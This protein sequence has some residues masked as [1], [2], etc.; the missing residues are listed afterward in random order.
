MASSPVLEGDRLYI[1]CDNDD[2]SF[3]LALD[4]KTGKEIWR[5]DR[6]E[7]STWAT[8]FI[9][10]NQRRTELITSGA[11]KMRSYDLD[12]K[13][14]WELGGPLSTLAIPSPFAATGLLFL[15]SGYV[16]DEARPVFA[17]KPGARGDITL[18]P[19]ETSNE[20]IAWSLPQGGPL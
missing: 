5:V 6:E 3:L 4:K 1:V 10:K 15:T 13:L 19:G 12:G 20:Y 16:G 18:K 8:P 14:L 17:V 2:K 11:K 7:P 9:W